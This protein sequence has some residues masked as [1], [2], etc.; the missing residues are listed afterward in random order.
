MPD[1]QYK[2]I[3]DRVA[4]QIQDLNLTDIVDANIVVRLMHIDALEKLLPGLPGVLVCHPQSANIIYGGGTN[5]RDDIGYPVLTMV[6]A[7]DTTDQYANYDADTHDKY[8][9]WHEQIRK[10]FINQRLLAADNSTLADL[11]KLEQELVVNNV[12]FR[13]Q[14]LFMGVCAWRFSMRE[15]RG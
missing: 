4:V 3:L 7:K 6:M 1:S 9:N 12:K 14:K 11:C 2:K 5:E 13:T 8:L 15:A 10:K